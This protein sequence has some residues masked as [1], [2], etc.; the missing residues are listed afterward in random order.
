MQSKTPKQFLLLNGVPIIVRTIRQFIQTL[1]E[2][3]VIVSCCQNDIQQF[4]KIQKRYLSK[5]P[6]VITK[7]G[8]T[9]FHSIQ[10]GLRAIK[11]DGIVAV[12]D[13][14]RP[15]ASQQLIKT[16][17]KIAEE[18]GNAVPMI[19]LQDSIRIIDGEKSKSLNRADYRLV[20]TPQCFK[21]SNL[22]HAYK[23]GFHKG[24]TDDASLAEMFGEKIN[25]VDG[26]NQNIKITTP[27]DMQ[28]AKLILESMK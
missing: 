22:K 9:R 17:F 7:G 8:A 2:I 5:L 26:E 18:K 27:I 20:Q 3:Q 21:V 16:C 10:S 6:L 1:P 28:I 13:A 19:S 14:V 11:T 24:I 12:Q 4:E 23:Q 15:F 25:L